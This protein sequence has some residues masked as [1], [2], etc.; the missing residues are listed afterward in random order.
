MSE[1]K[2]EDHEESGERV[3]ETEVVWKGCETE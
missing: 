1:Q 3:I 2:E